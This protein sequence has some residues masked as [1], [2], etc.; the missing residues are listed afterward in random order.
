MDY[1]VNYNRHMPLLLK[2]LLVCIKHLKNVKGLVF[3]MIV[4]CSTK[5]QD[6][7]SYCI[8]REQRFR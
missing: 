6:L 8:R 1:V 4:N 7:C 5:A 2:S 3:L